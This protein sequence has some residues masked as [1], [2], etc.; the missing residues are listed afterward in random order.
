V[1]EVLA[2]QIK[3]QIQ[4]N[5][6][7]PQSE[8]NLAVGDLLRTV[9]IQRKLSLDEIA[10]RTF[11]KQHYLEALESGRFNHLPAAV[12]TTGYIRQYA[13]ALNLDETPL[14]QSYQQQ[15]QVRQALEPL[16][17]QSP[18]QPVLSQQ[19]GQVRIENLQVPPAPNTRQAKEQTE[20]TMLQ[21]TSKAPP[22]PLLSSTKEV[23]TTIEGAR[24]EALAMRHQTE[25]FADQVFGHLENEIQ[26]TL[27]II[28]NGRGFLQQRLNT[29]QF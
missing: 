10:E 25:Q 16:Q 8:A 15:C 26:K 27:S 14:V 23:T 7:G 28:Q 13:R 18:F 29:Y 24:K 4:P 19:R 17:T 5:E 21:D 12:Y 3:P 22:S 11:I 2:T 20:T 6:S 1:N 9:R